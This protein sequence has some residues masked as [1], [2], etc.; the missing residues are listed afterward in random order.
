MKYLKLSC[1]VAVLFSSCKKDDDKKT[2]AELIV[3]K[4][5]VYN[6][7]LLAQDVPGDDSY[8]VFNS[9]G[10][11]CSGTDFRASDTTSG[12]FTYVLNEEGSYLAITDTTFAGG[13]Y[14]GTWDVLEIGDDRLRITITT[15]LGDLKIEMNKD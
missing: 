15:I 14:N 13:S 4:W 12:S 9:C 5:V 2:P 11:T 7:V 10:G 1:V 3:G 8:L 6:T